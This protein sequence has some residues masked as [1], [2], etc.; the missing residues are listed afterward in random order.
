MN[1]RI[2]LKSQ[3]NLIH[4]MILDK[5]LDP[6]DFEWVETFS[7]LDPEKIIS[8]LI[9]RH[10][11]FFYSFE[12]RGE[13]HFA[14]FS[15]ACQSYIGTDYPGT[16]DAQQ[17]CFLN[18][19]DLLLKE[20]SEPDLW[21]QGLKNIRPMKEDQ[22][23]QQTYIASPSAQSPNPAQFSS[24]LENLL[25]TTRLK[26]EREINSTAAPIHIKRYYGKA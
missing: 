4:G 10:S 2:L 15:P 19:L 8:R 5:G 11:D 6:R 18:W 14:I 21:S 26:A 16:W 13:S 9:N 12:M 22:P 23:R 7:D 24:R 25:E 1:K 3:K 17:R 20:K